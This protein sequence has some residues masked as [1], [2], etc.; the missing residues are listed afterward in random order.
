[1]DH[2]AKANDDL[3]IAQN[4]GTLHRN[5]QGYSTHADCDTIAMGITAISNIGDNYSQNV[6][7]IEDYAAQLKQNIIPIYRGLELE[8]D[9]VLR[10]EII[11]QLLC[12]FVIDIKKLEEKWRFSFTAYFKSTITN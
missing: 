5:F 2:F 9:D 1:M 8:A 11:N 6:R 10:K 4:T 3:V 12:H 7:T